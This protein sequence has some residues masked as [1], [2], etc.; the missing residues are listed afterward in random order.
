MDGTTSHPPRNALALLHRPELEQRLATGLDGQVVLLRAPAG[1][2]KTEAMASLYRHA[3]RRGRKAVW[4]TLTGK[5]TPDALRAKIAGQ[6]G[7]TATDPRGIFET[8]ETR[9]APTEVY[10]DNADQIVD[11]EVLSWLTDRPPDRLRLA[12]AGR[13]LPELRLSRLRMRGLLGEI[14]AEA[15]AFTPAEMRRL[16]GHR[17]RPEDLTRVIETL[18]GWP[19]LARLAL[20]ECERGARGLE[21]EAL[22]EGHARVYREFLHEEVLTSLAPKERCVL[23]AVRGIDSFT[24]RIA[25]EL[26]GQ[27]LDYHALRRIELMSPLIQPEPQ[28][29]GWFRLHPVVAQTLDSTEADESPEARRQRHSRAAELFAE[30]GT[31]EKSVLHASRAGDVALAVRTIESAGG[32]DLFLRAGYT[33]LRGIIRAVPHEAVLATPSLRLCRAVMLGKSG[34]IREARAVLDLLYED[35]RSGRIPADRRWM[36][37]LGHINTLTEVY[38]DKAMD[39]ASI[40]RFMT[41]VEDEHQENT[42]RLAWLYNHLAICYTRVGDLEAAQSSAM[43]GLSLYQ[44][45]RSSYPQVFMLI[46]LGFINYRANRPHQALDHLAQAGKLIAARHWNDA[47]LL[48]IANVPLAAI[49]YLQGQVPEA[50]ELLER[51]LPVLASGEGWVDFY[52]QG[53]ATLARA[54]FAQEGWTAAQE[55]LQEGLALADRRGLSRLRLSLSILR[56]ELHTR[57]GHLDAAATTIR[58]WP[59]PDRPETWPTPR[60]RREAGLAIGRLRLRANAVEEASRQLGA[61][62]EEARAAGRWELLIR[63]SLVLAEARARLGEDDGALGALQEAAT[64]SHPGRQVQQYRDQGPEF[65]DTIRKL[66]RR[67]GLSRLGPVSA[68]YLA[69]AAAT[70]RRTRKGGLLSRREAE[71]LALLAEGL[72]NKAIARRLEVS[73]PTVK[74]HLKNLYSKLGVGRRSLAVSVA[75]ASGLLD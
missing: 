39:E 45:E 23:R 59:D 49:R 25:S 4:I 9:P 44:E 75:R 7:I 60:E 50:R 72:P 68:Q 38:E 32:V 12:I 48:A 43:R 61:L 5:L 64:L 66:V 40:A 47:N 37:A 41:E 71:V 62:A 55:V 18:A 67:A 42:W 63:V 36:E 3:V 19:A 15:L 29:L 73:E 57:A 10:L 24:L 26:A 54:R 8:I 70:P 74:F 51:D 33:V 28:N 20:L 21:L 31:L 6:L 16:L 1:Y 17:L 34:Q 53:Y 56:A 58:Q 65:A 46:H 11:R 27:P 52:L 22:A 30:N 69:A 35:T 13:T 14:S 2:G